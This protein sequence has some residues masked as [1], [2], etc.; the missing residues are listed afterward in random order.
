MMN[1]HEDFSEGESLSQRVEHV[2]F[3][4]QYDVFVLTAMEFVLF[5]DGICSGWNTFLFPPPFL[6]YQWPNA[7]ERQ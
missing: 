6:F 1:M 4:S 7:Q 2:L 3:F 5:R